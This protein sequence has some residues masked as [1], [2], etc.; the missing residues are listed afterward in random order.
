MKRLFDL[1]I[2]LVLF[3]VLIPLFLIIGISI[4]IDS[5][6]PVF[7]KQNRIGR[8]KKE[9]LIY[10]FRTMKLDTP[11]VSTD[12][13]QDANNYITRL[14]NFLRKTSFDEL[15][16]LLNIIKGDMSFVGPRPALYN[17][18]E[19][20]D[21]REK[22]GVNSCT[23]GLTGYAQ[24]N[25]RDMITDVEKVKYDKYYTENISIVFDLK[26]IL[27]TFVKVILKKDITN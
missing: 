3:I 17:Q 5:R 27:N 12:K 26:I 1:V 14:G 11:N 10:K 23:P 13:L 15:P 2:S 6:G 7:F 24:I 4:K 18:Y 20:I 9:F 22:N 16:Q 21:L 19:L 8:H 25:G